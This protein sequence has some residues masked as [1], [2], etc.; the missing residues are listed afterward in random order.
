MQDRDRIPVQAPPP[1]PARRR[2][3]LAGAS[4][5]CLSALAGLSAAGVAPRAFSSEDAG[6]PPLD[7]EQVIETAK[8]RVFPALVFVKPVQEDL[9]GGEKRRVEVFGSGV[10]VDP[11]G[12]VVT[13]H[14]VAEK[15]KEIRC[16]LNDRR[17][18]DATVVGLDRATD[19]A[20]L[21][22]KLPPGERL[23]AAEWGSS[24]SLA[25]G[26]FVMAL[27]AP[28]GFERS[29]S[30]GIVSN[31]HRTLA[32][33]EAPYNVWIQ[34][35]AAIN[36]G[37]SGG[38]LVDTKGRVVGINTL[39]MRFASGLGFSIP[40]DVVRRVVTRIRADGRVVRSRTGVVLR[41][42]VDYLAN[43]FFAG[44]HG[45]I[46]DDVSPGTPAETAGLKKGDRILAIAGKPADGKYRED[47]PEIRWAL[48]DLPL[49]APATLTVER[50]G[51]K[52]DVVVTP[53]CE[54]ACDDP[55]AEAPRWGA[56]FQAISR[57]RVP[58]LAFHRK[59]GVYAFGVKYPGA[60][61]SAGLHELD[62]VLSIDRK[63]VADLA[64]LRAAYEE[65]IKDASPRH[66]VLVEVLRGGHRTYLAMKVGP[67][68][69]KDE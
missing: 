46:V 5:A 54:D 18:V 42:L 8:A 35:D 22:L 65:S 39:G 20:V 62:V 68:Q 43:T 24:A 36:P 40:V 50:D 6:K 55:A 56:T 4:L 47:L 57:E 1:R 7:F 67:E 34:T 49:G 63:P 41:P 38:P 23:P 17:E 30:L 3:A 26:Q 2:A 12:Y 69:K 37:N 11:E 31:A 61:A 15:A 45:V 52:I 44:D 10:I 27:G 64:A 66:T 53:D 51:K 13:N 29:I 25:E 48:A 58:D 60:A 33:D 59:S 21:K 16:V 32:D 9:S 19:L 14:H 28:Y